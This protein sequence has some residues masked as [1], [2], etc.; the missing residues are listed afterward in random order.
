MTKILHID[1]SPR[2][3]RSHSRRLAKEFI[4]AWKATHS[5]DTIV[6]RDLGH[7]SLPYLDEQWIAAAFSPPEKHTP[8]LTNAIALSDA[9]ID[10]FIGCDRYVFSIPMYNFFMPSI[11]K[12]YF[13]QI[14]RV[15][16]T[17]IVKD[18]GYKGLVEGKKALIIT[19]RGGSYQPGTP[20][21]AY[22]FQEPYLRTI[23][24]YIGI[25]DITFVHAENLSMGDEVRSQSLAQA[26]ATLEKLV[27]EW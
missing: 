17:F 26:K 15:N 13:D 22:D 8:E 21:A 18:G 23:F 5:D 3:E 10:E 16:R 20:A 24:G 14:V 4:S 2:V 19:S 6:Y 12:T 27:S 9:L 11:V 25:T 7:E 1:T